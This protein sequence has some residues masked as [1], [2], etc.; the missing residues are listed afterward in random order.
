MAAYDVSYL[1]NIDVKL[2]AIAESLGVKF[3][4]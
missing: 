4:E 1:K 2:K 3:K